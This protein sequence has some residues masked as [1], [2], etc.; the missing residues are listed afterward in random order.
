MRRNSIL[1]AER[2]VDTNR[3]EKTYPN[4]EGGDAQLLRRK[5]NRSGIRLSTTTKRVEIMTLE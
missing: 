5:E 2:G 4:P 1:I 3:Q